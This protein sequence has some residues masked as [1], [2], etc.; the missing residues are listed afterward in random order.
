MQLAK[1]KSVVP[2]LSFV[3]TIDSTN[4]ELARKH[5]SL[6]D[7]SV[8]VAAEQTS[9]QGR[10]GRSWIS[11][12]GASIAVSFLLRPTTIEVSSLVTLLAAASTHQAL[13]HLFP[14]IPISIKWPND[15]LIQDRK[16]AGILAHRNNDGSV[17]CG[18]GINLFPQSQAPDTAG[19]LSEYVKPD[20]DE[21]TAA[22]LVS[23]KTNWENIQ[24]SSGSS[25]LLDYVRHNCSTLGSEV[26]AELATGESIL[27]KATRITA[28]GH[29]VI[30]NEKEHTLAAADIWHLRKQ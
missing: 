6:P 4:A 29:L 1:S 17:V 15:I 10:A 16:L 20:F 26:R 22:V 7:F 9:G 18:I 25:S 2:G 8:L 24:S 28:D 12:P 11:M 19:A 13:G 27:G 3:Q 23:M 5:E 21:V 30:Q 14:S